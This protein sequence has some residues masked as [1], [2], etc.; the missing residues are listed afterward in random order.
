MQLFG[1][2]LLFI[3]DNVT[4]KIVKEQKMNVKKAESVGKHSRNKTRIAM[5]YLEDALQSLG[6]THYHKDDNTVLRFNIPQRGGCLI[7]NVEIECCVY[8]YPAVDNILFEWILNTK[9]KEV[10]KIL[11]WYL[12]KRNVFFLNKNHPN[13]SYYLYTDK[14][15]DYK[16]VKLVGKELI[17]RNIDYTARH[18]IRTMGMEISHSAGNIIEL[19][20]GRIP[21]DI[22]ERV[23]QEYLDYI[24]EITKYS[25]S[26]E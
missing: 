26:G 22:K 4:E 10:I 8:G 7:D 15:S 16:I 13:I 1:D 5:E 14:V 11:K 18:I 12:E 6:I 3:K 24:N 9:K 25:N 20:N 2:T 19:V 23:I 21:A 17:E